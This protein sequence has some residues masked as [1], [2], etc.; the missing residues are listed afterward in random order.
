MM[1]LQSQDS[2]RQNIENIGKFHQLWCSYR[3]NIKNSDMFGD[4][5]RK[6][7]G[8]EIMSQ[9]TSQAEREVIEKNIPGIDA[10][11]GDDDDVFF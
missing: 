4:T 6:E 7:F 2:I 8:N 1:A 9:M 10:G 5:Q 11:Y 3:L